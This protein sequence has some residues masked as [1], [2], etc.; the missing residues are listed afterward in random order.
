[1]VRKVKP[2]PV[3]KYYSLA[4]YYTK[5]Q[6]YKKAM[7]Y[8]E[9]ALSINPNH[10]DSLELKDKMSKFLNQK[11]RNLQLFEYEKPK[12]VKTLSKEKREYY[13]KIYKL[14]NELGT[15]EAVGNILGLTRERIRQLLKKGSRFGLFKYPPKKKSEEIID[16]DFLIKYFN[17]REEVLK[18]LQSTRKK[19]EMLNLLGTDEYNFNELLKHFGLTLSD[20][21][22]NVIK[23]ECQ[24][25]YDSYVKEIGYHPTTTE[26]RDSKYIRN[27]WARI[28]RYWGSMGEF[29]KEFNYPMV[30][31]GNPMLREHTREWLQKKSVVAMLKRKKQI[32]M[33]ESNLSEVEVMSKRELA[34]ASNMNEQNCLI[35]LN[36]MIKNGKII[37]VG[38]GN[39]TAYK[40]KEAQ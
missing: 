24:I 25:E 37:R 4:L 35:L 33:I 34:L 30:K 9:W 1:M 29:R 23:K 27:L 19:S 22:R 32:E 7:H 2:T 13:E 18:E 3:S 17:T 20:I 39:R 14:Y 31:Q 15:L 12:K 11:R 36:S 28:T 26:M 5:L 40:L 16:C 38:S 6:E 10:K 21:K 8:L